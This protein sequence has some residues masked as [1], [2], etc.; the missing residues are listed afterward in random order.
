VNTGNI[1]LLALV[2]VPFVVGGLAGIYPALFLSSFRPIQ[3]L[4][5]LLN[6]RRRQHVAAQGD[7]WCVQFSSIYHPDHRDGRGFPP[8]VLPAAYKT[9]ATTA[10]RW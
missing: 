6:S 3:V 8:A 1:I 5:G 4:K 10:S 2:A 7:S 9:W